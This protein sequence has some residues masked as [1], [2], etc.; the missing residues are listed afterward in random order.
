MKDAVSKQ[1]NNPIFVRN[2]SL[3]EATFLERPNRFLALVEISPEDGLHE[4]CRVD[5]ARAGI[6][7][8]RQVQA[9]V[10]DP[11]RLKELLVPGAKVY[12]LPA[13]DGEPRRG[14]GR[15]NTRKR[16][17]KHERKT[18]YTLV[19]VDYEGTLVSIDSRVPNA[20]VHDG[21]V[22]GFFPEFSMYNCIRSEATFGDSRLDFR[23]SVNA[24]P[25]DDSEPR[26]ED[27]AVGAPDC[28]VEVKSVTLVSD[29]RAL[30]PDAPTLRGARHMRELEDAVSKGF[31][32]SVIFVIQREDAES[33]SPHDAMDP[34]FG[35]ALRE[36]SASGVDI[37]AY[38]CCVSREAI[39][40][41][42]QVPVIL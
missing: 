25:S 10:A 22:K 26:V 7:Q 21:L 9:H 16:S 34:K 37:L 40:L 17:A 27:S 11:G 14:K 12:L 23:L 2:Q 30:F 42:W 20:L 28:L 33:F 38:T 8:R 41:G 4:S 36:A 35:E 29:K 39:T 6:A 32:A 1:D 3:I 31:N 5:G 13:Q 24:C 18:A 19:L 15:G